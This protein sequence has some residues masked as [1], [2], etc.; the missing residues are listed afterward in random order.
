MNIEGTVSNKAYLQKL[1]SQNSIV[2]VQEHWLWE[3]QKN[4]INQNF[5]G[6]ESFV[7]CHDSN[8]P[9]TNTH[10]PRGQSGIAILWS[11]KLSD[12][13]TRLEC[14][15]ERIQ[16]IELNVGNGSK[17]CLINTYL[18]TNKKDSEHNYCECL[19]VLHDILNRYEQSHQIILCGDLNGT[20]LLS[21]NN[22]H[23]I[24]LK[25][26]VN[27]HSL[28]NMGQASEKPT[29][30]HFSG[31]VTSQ[32]DYILTNM[33]NNFETYS[34]KDR[35]ALNISSH[36]PVQV[37]MK[38]DFVKSQDETSG[39]Y[40]KDRQIKQTLLWNKID[41]DTYISEI[42]SSLPTVMSKVSDPD[43]AVNSVMEC[44]IAAAQKAVPVKTVKLKGPK[45]RVSREV[46]NCMKKVKVTF[47]EWAAA[48]KPRTGHLYMENKLAKKH[49]RA[50]QR[51]EEHI[52]KNSLYDALMEQPSSE[53]FYKLISRSK[54][55]KESSTSCIQVNGQK[56][57]DPNQQRTC[58]ANYF[59]DL[60]MPKDKNYDS[61][62]LELCN[63][64]CGEI[65]NDFLTQTEE[66]IS[67]T[68]RN[69]EDAIDKLNSGKAP[70]E[71]G[72]SAEHL[73]AAKHVIVPVITETFNQIMK[74][75]T[76]PS[77][78]KTGI[79]TPVLKKGKD[80]KAMEN[81]R[82]ITVSGALGKLFE[83]TLLSKLNFTQSSQQFG[84]TTGLSPIM[85]GLL[86]SEAKSEI[87][88][89]GREGLFLATSFIM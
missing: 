74:L 46:L 70:D 44:L 10:I 54:S 58:F 53:M 83:Y 63:V 33:A 14:G 51:R 67:F 68:N 37:T 8:E 84:F 86:V 73:K 25:E 52:R 40:K 64:R 23:D 79:I 69:V 49:L 57:F 55:H 81:Y 41:I 71:Y 3:F 82:G 2:C 4:W 45:Q 20:L 56:H 59:E 28:S 76:V 5:C 9:I 22:K 16:A 21:R 7:R 85:A 13:I 1:L 43:S 75:K 66:S 47:R 19:D 35:D 39:S 38:V 24:L 62:F 72:L 29:Y 26:F 42:E 30:Y 60:A 15:N 88:C 32:I 78:F 34:I 36:V 11:K 89:Q 50:N 18:P 61:V 27:E 80:A 77:S 6:I 17:I 87:Q 12:K 48:G 31:V 65:E